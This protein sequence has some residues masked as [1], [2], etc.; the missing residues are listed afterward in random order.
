MSAVLLH[1]FQSGV[2]EY[3]TSIETE[4]DMDASLSCLNQHRPCQSAPQ[5]GSQLNV[6]ELLAVDISSEYPTRSERSFSVSSTY[7]MPMLSRIW[8]I[9]LCVLP[10]FSG[11]DILLV[12]SSHSRPGYIIT[13]SE[14]SHKDCQ[15]QAVPNSPSK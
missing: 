3:S 15:V 1:T 14:A 12:I 6:I 7:P 9:F 11:T 8:R 10:L 2:Q 5:A 13:E 4:A